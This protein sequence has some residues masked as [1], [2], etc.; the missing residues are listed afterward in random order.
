M[1][2]LFMLALVLTTVITSAFSENPSNTAVL[3][4]FHTS[5]VD[6]KNVE[7]T[8]KKDF[9]RAKFTINDEV[10]YAYY[11]ESGE[12]IAVTR[13]ITTGQLPLALSSTLFDKHKDFY[14]S[15]LFEVSANGESTYYAAIRKGNCII[16]LQASATGD[17]KFFK[18]ERV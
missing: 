15:N 9:H 17:W 4:A 8:I 6:A 11:K 2:K 12:L 10:M 16:T 14:L 3:N 7:W 5:F 13:N 1:K 18:K